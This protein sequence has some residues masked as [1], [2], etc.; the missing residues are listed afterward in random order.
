MKNRSTV[1]FVIPHG[2]QLF[3]PERHHRQGGSEVQL[4]FLA[5]ELA[6]RGDVRPVALLGA[7]GQPEE[8]EIAGVSLLSFAHK[9]GMGGRMSL[10]RAIA[11]ARPNVIVQ[12]GS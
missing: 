2:V 4:A 3:Y 1:I 6:R 7:H 8:D 11:R 9:P 5:R 10:W 12:R